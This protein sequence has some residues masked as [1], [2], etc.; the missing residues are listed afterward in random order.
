VAENSVTTTFFANEKD[1]QA[2]IVRLEKKY[3][4]LEAKIKGVAKSS[5]TSAEQAEDGLKG[6]VGGLASMAA[7]YVALPM[8][9]SRVISA[10]K[11]MIDQADQASLK[12]DKLFR[13]LRVQAGLNA[14]GGEAAQ[15]K[16]TG[17]AIKNAVTPEFA[18]KAATQ[19]VSSGF[20][21][22]DATG[23]ALDIFLQGMK[24]GNMAEG[25]PKEMV[26]SFG[27]FLAAQ[28]LDKNTENLKKAIVY[29]QRLFKTGDLEVSDLS[30]LAGRSQAAQGKLS[31]EETFGVFNTLRQKTGADKSATAFQALI[32][33]MTGFSG[34][35]MATKALRK[36]GMKPGDTDLVGENIG[37]ALDRIAAGAE[38]IPEE[39][40]AA[41]FQDL[42]GR[43]VGSPIHGLIRDRAEIPKAMEQLKDTSGFAGDVATATSGK[44][45]AR[46][47]FETLK[48]QEAAARDTGTVDLFNAAETV[49]KEQGWNWLNRK[50]GRLVAETLSA[51]GASDD[52]A[53][54]F[55]FGGDNMSG[56]SADAIKAKRAELEGS[57]AEQARLL[58]A[59]NK[60][61]EEIAA[62]TRKRPGRESGGAP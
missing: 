5:R 36:A 35:P 4:D 60:F 45:A 17:L 53:L 30:A 24:A 14:V 15:G 43:E 19:L 23:G 28:G 18:A 58:E 38:R 7:G 27:Q 3:A 55:G 31:L 2:A 40:R 42:F 9:I 39:K 13:N 21:P 47:R 48:E 32:D 22:E 56:P 41:W 37:T 34:D 1:A 57:A 8:L 10:N 44:A 54:T 16:V 26:Q 6:W 46:A 59:N 49:A 50:I 11:E 25:D 61:L 62:N 33:R 51:A 20:S 29:S 12:Y 52:T